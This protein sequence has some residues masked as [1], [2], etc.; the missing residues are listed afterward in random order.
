MHDRWRRRRR[1][2]GAVGRS[3]R[4]LTPGP[5]PAMRGGAATATNCIRAD[6]KTPA[7]GLALLSGRRRARARPRMREIARPRA[8]CKTDGTAESLQRARAEAG[9]GTKPGP[10]E[11]QREGAPPNERQRTGRPGDPAPR[12]REESPHSSDEITSPGRLP[13]ELLLRRVWNGPVVIPRRPPDRSSW[14]AFPSALTPPAPAHAPAP[15]FLLP[16]S[17]PASSPS[18]RSRLFL[19]RG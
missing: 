1:R 18:L 9:R 16:A 11:S 6:R 5:N 14:G 8:H 17:A 7:T 15:A 4:A 10:D 19:S 12:T 2:P 13:W 3:C